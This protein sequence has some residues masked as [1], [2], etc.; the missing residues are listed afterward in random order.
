MVLLAAKH[1]LPLEDVAKLYDHE[2]AAL[3]FGA[4]I[5]KFLH[6]FATR[7]VQDI[8]RMRDIDK[9]AVPADGRPLLPVKRLLVALPP[10]DSPATLVIDIDNQ[11]LRP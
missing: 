7:N 3:A 2:H 11:P 9:L 5:T 10:R 4:H 1:Q 6:V 8:L